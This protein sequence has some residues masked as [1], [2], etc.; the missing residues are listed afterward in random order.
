MIELEDK[1]GS[2]NILG[3]IL[4]SFYGKTHLPDHCYIELESE[5]DVSI[6]VRDDA[7]AQNGLDWIR[8]IDE[9][10]SKK[11]L[12]VVALF[13]YLEEEKLAYFVGDLSLNSLG[14]VWSDTKY[15]RCEFLDNDLKPLIFKYSRK[16]IFVSETL[17]ILEKNDFKTDEELRHEEEVSSMKK[18]LGLTQVALGITLLGLLVS[19]FI[20]ILVTSTVEIEK[21]DLPKPLATL[22]NQLK[23]IGDIEK[24]SNE[25]I[26]D[27]ESAILSVQESINN[28]GAPKSKPH[29]QKNQPTADSGG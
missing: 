28:L 17:R 6:Q 15:T 16:K 3:N 7:L 2:L 11:L 27:L 12:T 8:E 13:Q 23:R 22:E 20:P 21:S 18:Q 25:S 1:V 19:I 24:A 14:E 26:G 10:I 9:D 4:D 29:N 5:R